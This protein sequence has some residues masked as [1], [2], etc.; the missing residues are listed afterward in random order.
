MAPDK[1]IHFRPSLQEYLGKCLLCGHGCG[2]DRLGGEKGRCGLGAEVMVA[3]HL[4]HF[5]EEPPLSGSQGSG[6]IFFSGC[7]MSCV[8]CQNYQISRQGLGRP[9]EISELAEIMLDLQNRQAHNINL[10]SPTPWVPQIVEA[11][12][13]A[14]G[15]GLTLPI[16]YN[17]GGFDSLNALRL[18]NG[19]VDVYLPDAKYPDRAAAE[20]YSGAANYVGVNHEAL[21]EMFRQV[22]PLVMDGAGLA[23]RGLLVRHLVLPENLAGTDRVLSWLAGHFGTEIWISLMAQYLPCHRV[24]GEPMLFPELTRP[25]TEAEYE[26]AIDAAWDLGLEN[27]FIQDLSAP[28]VY[29]PDFETSEVFYRLH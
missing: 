15:W 25:L 29:V 2:V 17:S 3:R 21:K 9:V 8:F 23:Q 4:L 19:V 28:S 22:G 7:P 11:I 27:V 20:L 16:V 24:V 13:Q 1:K 14:R 10:V 18:L 6:T 12:I 26:T 5:G